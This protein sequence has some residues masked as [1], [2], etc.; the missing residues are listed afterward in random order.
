MKKIITTILSVATLLVSTATVQA[1]A[2]RIT[3]LTYVQFFSSGVNKCVGKD[4]SDDKALYC[5]CAMS[6]TTDNLRDIVR[7]KK[8]VYEYQMIPY[9]LRVIPSY[10]ELSSCRE[11][12]DW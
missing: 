1:D 7:K 3:D 11:L 4:K 6:M 12:A 9:L 10:S 8:L 2:T 5:V